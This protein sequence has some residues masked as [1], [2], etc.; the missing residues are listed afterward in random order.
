MVL[1]LLCDSLEQTSSGLVAIEIKQTQSLLGFGCKEQVMPL[2]RWKLYIVPG[3]TAARQKVTLENGF[4]QTSLT[5]EFGL[6]LLFFIIIIFYIFGKITLCPLNCT[7]FYT[8]S[9]K[10]LPVRH[11]IPHLL[12]IVYVFFYIFWLLYVV[13]IKKSFITNI[14]S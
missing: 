5:Y 7:P 9:S 10:V 1:L 11:F 3:H 4:L 2:A 12:Y 13:C 14:F 8:Y 6:L